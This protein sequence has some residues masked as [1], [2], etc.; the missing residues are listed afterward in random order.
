MKEEFSS[1]L[2]GDGIKVVGIVS[3]TAIRSPPPRDGLSLR[4]KV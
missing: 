3:F 2:G 4:Y 1:K